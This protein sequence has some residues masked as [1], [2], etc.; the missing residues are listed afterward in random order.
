METVSQRRKQEE[1]GK[2]S[3]AIGIV[4]LETSFDS[5]GMQRT[6]FTSNTDTARAMGGENGVAAQ[7]LF[8]TLCCGLHGCRRLDSKRPV[9]GHWYMVKLEAFQCMIVRIDRWFQR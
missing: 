4:A 6:D 9:S 8:Q 7:H 2:C 3:V 5:D 1:R